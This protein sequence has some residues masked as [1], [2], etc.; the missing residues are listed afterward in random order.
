MYWDNCL[1]T[2][3]ILDNPIEGIYISCPLKYDPTAKAVYSGSSKEWSKLSKIG[4]EG[5]STAT[6]VL[7]YE[8]ITKM[9]DAGVVSV[10][11]KLMTFVDAR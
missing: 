5:R 4:S 8:N 3:D 10:D 6:T 1:K 7:S 11:R 9:K 2:A